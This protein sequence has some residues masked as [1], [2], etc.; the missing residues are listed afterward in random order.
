MRF[1][2]NSGR[3]LCWL[4]GTQGVR[5]GAARLVVGKGKCA[6][7][8]RNGSES[9]DRSG[10][11]RGE[12]SHILLPAVWRVRQTVDP[13]GAGHVALVV[14]GMLSGPVGLVPAPA[15]VARVCRTLFCR[16][17]AIFQQGLNLSAIGRSSQMAELWALFQ[18]LTG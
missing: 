6:A 3:G 17:K 2:E 11:Q 1:M 4:D 14:R 7:T 8:R 15:R 10:G 12:N 16:V 13:D 5:S 18:K 9:R